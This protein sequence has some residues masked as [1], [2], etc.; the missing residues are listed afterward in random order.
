MSKARNRIVS[1]AIASS[2]VAS[3]CGISG[4]VAHADPS[5]SNSRSTVSAAQASAKSRAASKAQAAAAEKAA[6]QKRQSLAAAAAAAIEST[7]PTRTETF[8]KTL[9]NASNANNRQ[10]RA[11]LAKAKVEFKKV[12]SA[13]S[14]A[15]K[16]ATES[17]KALAAAKKAAAKKAK[18][19][20]AAQARVKAGAAN[21][22]QVTKASKLVSDG[23]SLSAATP[24]VSATRAVIG[25]SLSE[26]AANKK[27][28]HDAVVAANRAAR[29]VGSLEDSNAVL[30]QR[31][32]R[33]I[34]V[35]NRLSRR[36]ITAEAKLAK[37]MT[38]TEVRSLDMQVPVLDSA[39]AI[40]AYIRELN[41]NGITLVSAAQMDSPTNL[42]AGYLPVP[43]READP[44]AK[45]DGSVSVTAQVPAA[46]VRSDNSSSA[47]SNSTTSTTT[48]K[49][50][51]KA[52]SAGSEQSSAQAKKAAVKAARSAAAK[53]SGLV[54]VTSSFQTTTIS[55][56][57]SKQQ[58]VS[59]ASSK[60]SKASDSNV[61]SSVKKA[62]LKKNSNASTDIAG[63]WQAGVAQVKTADGKS[64]VILPKETLGALYVGLN[65]VGVPYLWGG[66]TP[67]GFDC[68][69]LMGFMLKPLGI[70]LPR[71]AVDQQN[72]TTHVGDTNMLPGDMVY[73][74]A[75]AH[76]VAMYV[77][78]GEMLEAPRTGLDVRVTD[79]RKITNASRPTLDVVELAK[80]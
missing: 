33:A 57:P 41:A 12:Q 18:R 13:S 54:T 40:D 44:Y 11:N 69:G 23:G 8:A 75:A 26:V 5:D 55:A 64:L 65:Q 2:A 34:T 76:H 43:L 4:G 71:V 72:S 51:K 14:N 77:G 73:F 27:A 15:I 35:A 39:Q 74:G 24:L 30:H 68:S 62:N 3:I 47:D 42:P 7:G 58:T 67:A 20:L 45:A 25:V 61:S 80:N 56:D 52:K 50:T 38:M 29:L 16:V 17:D 22:A 1:A 53:K 46:D 21:A 31:E 19:S 6:K 48:K 70:N 9:I 37:P 60:L 78:G 79:L 59:D 63:K 32:T 49:K 28:A 36:I 66:V 10:A